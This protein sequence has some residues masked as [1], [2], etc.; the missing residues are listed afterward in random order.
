MAG[1]LDAMVGADAA[2]FARIEPVI[3]TWAANVVPLGA[4][5]L[6]HKMKLVNNFVAMGQAALIAEALAMARK[7]GLTIEQ[8]H[9]VIG[10]GRMRSGFYDTF[11]QWS[12]S[13]DDKAHLFTITNAHKDMRYVS[14]MAVEAG[15]LNPMQAQVRNAFAAMDAAGQGERYV[16]MLADFVA[17]ANGLPPAAQAR[18]HDKPS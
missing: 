17:V 2:T 16:P 3:R 9:A 8:F 4:V 6:A 5:G 11:M 7:A 12:L 18:S 10:S 14:S 1:T 15:A 13:G